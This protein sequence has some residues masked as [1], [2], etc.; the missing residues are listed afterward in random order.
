MIWCKTVLAWSML[1]IFVDRARIRGSGTF[2]A[3]Q[4]SEI[5]N[6]KFLWRYPFRLS[7]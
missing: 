7:V 6:M 1:E 3:G 2:A 5:G 4:R